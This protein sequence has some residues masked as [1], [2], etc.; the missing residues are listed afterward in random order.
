[1][2]Y[3]LICLDVDGTLLD[4]AKR[5][6]E[7]V[8][9]SLAKAH[10]MG[11]AIALVTGRMPA[12][13]ALIERE[14]SLPCIKACN[15]GTYIL[16]GEECI[17]SRCLPVEAA[18]QIYQAFF[19]EK[20]LPL[21]IFEGKKWYVTAMD[22]YVEREIGIIHV[23]P[24]FVDMDALVKKW[25]EKGGAPNKL[26]A[27][28]EPSI[29]S[30]LQ[31]E[32]KAMGISGVDMARSSENYLEI[33]PQGATKGEALEAIC[34][35]LGILLEETVAFGDQELDIP[36]LRKAGTAVAMG[37]AIGEVKELADFVTKSNNEAGI[38]FALEHYLGI[39]E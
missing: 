39:D 17:H 38:A 5:V 21:W 37:N 27:G 1:M 10:A 4:D 22:A 12:A 28:A 13:T 19:A 29:I 25:K 36:M 31:G 30:R 32:M 9:E 24:E 3:K 6:L 8:K 23:Q 16:F 11:I 2:R 15:A 18:H 26:L 34:R 35:R 20:N 33:F 14:L 7:P